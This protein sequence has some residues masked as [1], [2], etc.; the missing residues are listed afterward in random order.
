MILNKYLLKRR[1]IVLYKINLM[2]TKIN[3][4]VSFNVTCSG[5]R[6]TLSSWF[7]LA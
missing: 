3:T 7:D 6:G 4:F 5:Y 1:N 2:K